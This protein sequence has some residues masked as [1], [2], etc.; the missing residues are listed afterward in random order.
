M[1][2]SSTL[3][4]HGLRLKESPIPDGKFHRV[5]TDAKPTRKNGWYKLAIDG[6][7]GWF[8]DYTI[9]LQSEWRAEG[10]AIAPI[11]RVD[12]AKLAA[13]RAEER[14]IA[15]E[16]IAGARRCWQNLQPMQVLHPYLE[17]K[18][19]TVRGGDAIRIDHGARWFRSWYK[20]LGV[21]LNIKDDLIVVPMTRA[22]QLVSLQA[23]APNGKK[24]FWKNAPT[25]GTS[26][27]LPRPGS[28]ITI[29]TEGFATGL[30]LFQC[31]PSATI[32]I[33]FSADNM[34]HVAEDLNLTGMVVVA[35]DNDHETERRTGTNPGIDKGRKAAE[36]IGCQAAWPEGIQGSD[37]LDYLQETDSPAGVRNA[38]LRVAKLVRK[39]KVPA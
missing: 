2:F 1:D 38:V 7:I 37:W 27:T 11:L 16:A 13:L 9:G 31:V 14:K 12:K 25:K 26:L 3:I 8:G 39:V 5:K 34:A 24:L 19:L 21:D 29:L 36:A 30:C 10:K 17:S 4:A 28:T 18:Q 6:R 23:I 15:G 35:A 33:C 32:I 22:G 20:H